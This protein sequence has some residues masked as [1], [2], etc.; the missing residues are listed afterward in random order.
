MSFVY[1]IKKKKIRLPTS[2][3]LAVARGIVLQGLVDLV[4]IDSIVKP[5]RF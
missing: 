5:A 2:Q 1:V 4:G 3:R